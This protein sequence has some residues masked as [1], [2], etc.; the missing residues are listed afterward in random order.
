VRHLK[1]QAE[2]R[3]WR[4]PACF[5]AKLRQMQFEASIARLSVGVVI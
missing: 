3:Q 2:F 1:M 4:R 5:D